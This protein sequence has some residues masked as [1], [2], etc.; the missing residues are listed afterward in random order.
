MDA[1]NRISINRSIDTLIWLSLIFHE[2]PIHSHCSYSY[3]CEERS[4]CPIAGELSHAGATSGCEIVGDLSNEIYQFL[5]VVMSP[6]HKTSYSQDF[7]LLDGK[8]PKNP[9]LCC[10]KSEAPVSKVTCCSPA[11]SL[12]NSG[13]ISHF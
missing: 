13:A 5:V 1:D 2:Y 3:R 7:Y 4:T 8:S 11:K 12:Q 10:L 6:Y 9:T